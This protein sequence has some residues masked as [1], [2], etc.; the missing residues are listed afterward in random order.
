MSPAEDAGKSFTSVPALAVWCAAVLYPVNLPPSEG[1]LP[2][3]STSSIA[4]DSFSRQQ[5]NHLHP[6]LFCVWARPHPTLANALFRQR[7]PVA[8]FRSRVQNIHPVRVA[9]SWAT[10]ARVAAILRADLP[11]LPPWRP[12]RFRCSGGARR[13][14]SACMGKAMLSP[15]PDWRDESKKM[16]V[17]ASTTTRRPVG[18]GTEFWTPK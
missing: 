5:K 14:R 1:M 15:S 9:R 18:C 12:L 3:R 17:M 13:V 8:R 10:P 7:S 11:R 6:M 4:G 2:Q 16:H